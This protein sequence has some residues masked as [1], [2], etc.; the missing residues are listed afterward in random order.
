MESTSNGVSLLLLLFSSCCR[1]QRSTF[2]WTIASFPF[3]L[4]FPFSQSNSFQS[5]ID[6]LSS[7]DPDLHL[8]FEIFLFLFHLAQA[9]K[10]TLAP[11]FVSLLPRLLFYVSF[12]SPFFVY[13]LE[14]SVYHLMELLVFILFFFHHL[15]SLVFL[16]YVCLSFQSNSSFLLG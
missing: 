7:L 8:V 1:I 11:L 15:A 14:F 4:V 2:S 12:Y 3:L 9:F 13:H 6:L 10:I 5:L 16:L